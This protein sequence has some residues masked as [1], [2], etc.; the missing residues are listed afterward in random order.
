[1]ATAVILIAVSLA[2]C[3]STTDPVTANVRAVC[4]KLGFNP[5]DTGDYATLPDDALADVSALTD[6]ASAAAQ[7]NDRWWPLT[8]D[9]NTLTSYAQDNDQFSTWGQADQEEMLNAFNG[10]HHECNKAYAS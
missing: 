9:L 3:T 4:H 5:S 2:A 6:K 8:K 7:K 10:A 1:M